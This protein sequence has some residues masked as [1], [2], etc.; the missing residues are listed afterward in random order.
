[1][2]TIRKILIT[3]GAGYIGNELIRTLPK[4]LDIVVVDNFH[5]DTPYKRIA[6]ET[7]LNGRRLTLVES[8]VSQT[9]EYERLLKDTDV[10]VYMASLNSFRESNLDPLLYLGENGTN[11]QIFLEALK[12]S[13]SNVRKFVLTSTRGVYGEGPYA[14]ADCGHR[15]NPPLAETLQC[16]SC[17]GIRVSPRNIRETDAVNPTSLYGITKKLQE[18]LLTVHCREKGVPIDIFRIFNVYGENQGKYYSNIGIIPQIYEQIVKRGEMYLSGNGNISRDFIHVADVAGVL[19]DS[20]LLKNRRR[21]GKEIY[22]LGSGKSVSINDIARFFENKG[23]AFGKKVS[24]E[25]NDIQY[26]VADNSK[27][28]SDFKRNGFSDVY[29]FLDNSYVTITT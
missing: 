2:E 25:F 14:C 21:D 6:N 10:V 7:L 18:D 26:S 29:D 12:R 11:L 5:I 4:T 24:K 20:V 28:L 27:V 1:M 8:D 15:T 13:G 19:A 23:Y 22:N 9:R 17:S 3:G 16:V